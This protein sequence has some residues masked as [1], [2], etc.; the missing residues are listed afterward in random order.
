MRPSKASKVRWNL[1]SKTR[2][3]VVC[4]LARGGVE[5]WGRLAIAIGKNIPGNNQEKTEIW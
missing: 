4:P 3:V 2:D 5:D 1:L